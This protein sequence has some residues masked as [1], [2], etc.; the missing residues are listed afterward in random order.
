MQNLASS[1]VT[2]RQALKLLGLGAA[3]GAFPRSTSAASLPFPIDAGIRTVLNDSAPEELAGAATLFHEHMSYP[4]DFMPRWMKYSADTR[5]ANGGSAAANG[6][7]GSGSGGRAGASG[8]AVN[9]AGQ[10]AP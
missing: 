8:A 10:T 9:S 2:R 7:G 6:G 4:P 1:A 5:A 3:V